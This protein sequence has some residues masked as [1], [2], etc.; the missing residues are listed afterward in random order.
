M[1]ETARSTL[2]RLADERAALLCIAELVAGDASPQ[3]VLDA[4]VVQAAHLVDVNFTALLRYEPDGATEVVAVHRPPDGIRVGMRSGATGT[5]A[6]QQVFTTGRPA[7]IDDLSKAE[8]PWP[9]LAYRLGFR[10]SAATPVVVQ[11]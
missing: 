7:R 8:G 3:E 10:S 6:V 1:S 11:G 2:Q 5:G 9:Q 4:V